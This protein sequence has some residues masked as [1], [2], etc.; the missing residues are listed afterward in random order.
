MARTV[1]AAQMDL[2]GVNS[3]GILVGL[4]PQTEPPGPIM[5]RHIRL[6]RFGGNKPFAIAAA[7]V[8]AVT[9]ST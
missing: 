1:T 5:S 6:A 8:A 4:V 7:S 9:E 2:S 3:K